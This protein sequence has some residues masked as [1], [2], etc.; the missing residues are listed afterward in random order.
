MEDRL[1]PCPFCGGEARITDVFGRKGIVCKDCYAEMRGC[2][3]MTSDEIARCWNTRKPMDRIVEHLRK[4]K[5]YYESAYKIY[6]GGTFAHIYKIQAKT[7]N[8]AIEIVKA[9]GLNE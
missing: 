2:L 7:Y 5:L 3:D 8:K 4:R 1:K 9:G 6:E